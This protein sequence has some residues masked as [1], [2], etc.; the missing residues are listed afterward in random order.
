MAVSGEFGD[1]Q[2]QIRG[3]GS[4]LAGYGN[5]GRGP[6]FIKGQRRKRRST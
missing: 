6:R 5:Q 4:K 3:W 2:N 1:V